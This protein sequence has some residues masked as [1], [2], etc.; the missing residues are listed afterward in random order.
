MDR[1]A[2]EAIH[3]YVDPFYAEC[4]AYGRFHETGH[5]ELALKCY[6]Y[7]LLD[8]KH[9]QALRDKEDREGSVVLYRPFYVHADEEQLR[10]RYIVK[11]LGSPLGLTQN[12]A[13]RLLDDVKSLHQL[14]I[15]G[16]DLRLEQLINGKI[17][18][19]SMAMT[20]PHFVMSPQLNPS[21]RAGWCMLECLCK[22]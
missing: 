4:R 17:A 15:A 19:F 20:F 9:E 1:E 18:D 8:E 6:G 7:V 11:E 14:G 2:P 22:M 13:Y 12:M 3:Q 21:L 5:D 10:V 16:L